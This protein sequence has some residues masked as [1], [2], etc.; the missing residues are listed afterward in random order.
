MLKVKRRWIVVASFLSLIPLLAF[1]AAAHPS[2]DDQSSGPIRAAFYYPWFP[3]AWRIDRVDRYT[4]YSPSLGSYDSSRPEVIRRHIAGMQYGR[5]D[6]G[7]LSWW[8]RATPSD[9]RIPKI[10]AATSGT[11]FHWAIYYEAEGSR[12]PSVSEIR[13]DLIYLRDRYA[14]DPGLLRIEGRF[15]V[16]VYADPNDAC[17]MADRWSQANKDVG[18]FVV[19]KVFVG[20]RSCP[21]QPDGWHQYAPAKAADVQD[22]Y[23]YTISPGF[24]KFGEPERLPRDLDRW[25]QNIRAMI[26]SGARFQLITSFNEWGEGTAVESAAEWASPSGYGL[27]LDALHNDGAPPG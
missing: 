23:S 3:E 16:F 15:V 8:G 19:L 21:N 20:Y 11:G 13:D 2:R 18:A 10:L 5:I 27:Y 1:A 17:G 9:A 25:R 22:S 14:G 26:A 24:H 6:A 12:D 7:I 4:V